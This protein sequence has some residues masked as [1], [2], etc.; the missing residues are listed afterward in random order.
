MP[1]GTGAAP[2]KATGTK[3]RP[4]SSPM[5]QTKKPPFPGK[6]K[7]GQSYLPIVWGDWRVYTDM[8]KQ[9]WRAKKVG[10]RHDI[11]AGWGVDPEGAWAK[12]AGH[13]VT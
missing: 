10:E 7:T 1:S 12:L 8:K 6:P 5:A 13:L 4:A 2:I 9:S 3:K 11:S